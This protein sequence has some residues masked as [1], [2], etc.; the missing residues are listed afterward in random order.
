MTNT[1]NI[2]QP[3]ISDVLSDH[4]NSN[5]CLNV[6]TDN[7][8]TEKSNFILNKNFINLN[9]SN[10]AGNG[11]ESGDVRVSRVGDVNYLN[12]LFTNATSLNN[13]L[14]ELEARI[15]SLLR[16]HLVLIAETWFGSQSAPGIQGYSLYRKDRPTRGGGVAIYVRSELVVVEVVDDALCSDG[17]EQVWCGVS[18]GKDRILVGCI[19]RPPGSNANCEKALLDSLQSA[20]KFVDSKI[21]DSVLIAGDFNL[22]DIF[23]SPEG[24]GSASNSESFESRFLT[25][26]DDCFMSQCISEPT[27]HRGTNG[28][29]GSVLDLIITDAEDRIRDIEILPPLGCI[30][31]AHSVLKWSF[32]VGQSGSEEYCVKRRWRKGRY[33]AMR[34]ELD[35]TNWDSTF[36][37]LDLDCCYDF[38]AQKF[39]SQCEKHVPKMKVSARNSPPWMTQEL[40]HSI[41]EKHK[42][43]YK[44]KSSNSSES[45]ERYRHISAKVKMDIKSAVETY[46]H[47]LATKSKSNPKLIYSYTRSKQNIK[48]HIRAVHDSAGQLVTEREII[49]NVL[50]EQFK[51]V[52]VIEPECEESELPF[53]ESRKKDCFG[54]DELIGCVSEGAV[55]NA[56]LDLCS[57]KARGV[58][59]INPYV[60]K[61]CASSFAKPLSIIFR[62]SLEESKIPSSWKDAN[63][64]PIFKKGSR[65][66]AANYRPVSLTSVV[67][68]LMERLV[69]EGF[70]K[71]LDREGLISKAQHGFVKNKTC[72]TNL[73]E[74]LDIV[75]K[76]LSDGH[77]VDMVYLDFLKA[78]DM[79]PHRR[80]IHKLKGYGL[81]SDLLGW[82]ESFLS[83]RRQ[84]VVLGETYSTWVNVT[85]GVPQGSVLGPILFL[86]Y[87]NDL[88][89]RFYNSPKLYADDSK[90]IAIIKDVSCALGLQNDIDNLTE[91]TRAWLMRLNTN[92][93]KVMHFGG[94]D[95]EHNVYTIEDLSTGI[96]VPLEVSQCERDLGVHISSDLKWKR[97]VDSIASKANKILG[98]LAKT[99]TCRDVDLWKTLYISLVRPHLEF[100]SS[101][102]N[103]YLK[104]DIDTLEKVQHRAS[105]IPTELKNLPYEKRLEKWNLT[106][107]EERRARGDIIQMYKVVRGHESFDW[108]T[109]PRFAPLTQ[110]RSA[111]K[112]CYRLEMENITAKARND[113]CHFVSTRENF[114]LNRVNNWN[115]VSISDTYPQ[116]L[117]S[118]KAHIDK[119]QNMAAIAL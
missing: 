16:P 72:T 53:F 56:L 37:S 17:V 77:Q 41:K 107:L 95:N 84:R 19:Y 50:N 94:S 6:K 113:F 106:T 93:C 51:S 100:A 4:I 44:M 43:W 5:S 23:W 118:F 70:I 20:K 90:I 30:Q 13:K 87:I 8:K 101:V 74:T 117:N 59:G 89:E 76:S 80:L 7:F 60:L 25:T 3:A 83:N 22:P 24:F 114:F 64:T 61:E 81:R 15:S 42:F 112:N 26:L 27:F 54:V 69:R 45:K 92:K 58:D 119:H 63:V 65:V 109:G 9:F 85:S 35:Q 103:P 18:V 38:L 39:H 82:F 47:N 2:I 66:L 68:K 31:S 75:T 32:A 108:F 55:K 97:H 67:C 1:S 52:F 48:D 116:S 33:D 110:T 88:P 34:E 71:Y 104:G 79:V 96:K 62:R 57:N 12:C 99:F 21:Y 86:L 46:E 49:A 111:S 14:H 105:K 98:M 36:S 73:L 29:Y 11:N 10:K 115:R 91:W 78:F 28:S 40:K 102:W